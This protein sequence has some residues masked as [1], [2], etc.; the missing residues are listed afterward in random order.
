[1]IKIIPYGQRT[2]TRKSLAKIW[3]LFPNE[4][5][6]M[7]GITRDLDVLRKV[8]M[9]AYYYT[10]RGKDFSVEIDPV[11]Y[12]FELNKLVKIGVK[13]FYFPW[14][15]IVRGLFF[16]STSVLEQALWLV[17]NHEDIE[18][19]IIYEPIYDD[20]YHPPDFDEIETSIVYLGRFV[21]SKTRL[22]GRFRRPH[23]WYGIPR[24]KKIEELEKLSL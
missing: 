10:N 14:Y 13:K 18:V 22:H 7:A 20:I 9:I 16:S 4:E 1:M 5:F 23:P 6:C 17:E 12:T 24:I 15:G 8:N 21:N 3:N 2:L 11:K 19:T